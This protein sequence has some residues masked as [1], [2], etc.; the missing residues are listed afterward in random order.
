MKQNFLTRS[1]AVAIATMMT[2]TGCYDDSD[3][4][5]RMDQAEA[6]IAELQQ[7]VKDINTNISGLVTVVD[8]LKNSDQITSVTPLSDGSGYTITFSK[9]GTITIYNGKNGGDGTNGTN[10][11]TGA[12][13]HTP[14]I[15]VKLDQDGQYYWTVDGEYLTD[16]EGKK[17]PATAHIATPQ[18]RINEGNFEISYN[19]GLTWEV[20][21]NAGASDDVVFK[22]VID[23]PASV[24]FVL[25][26]GTQIEI[27]K[28]QQFEINVTSTDVVASAGQQ[29]FVDFTVSGA[30]ENTVVDA[31]GTKGYEASVMMMNASTGSLTI[32]VPDPMT[33]GKVYLMAVK[34]DGSTAARIFSCEEGVF[35]VDETAFAAKVPAA[36]GNVEVPVTTNISGWGVMVDP[37]NLWIKHVETKA[38]R[39]ETVVLSVEENTSTEERTG[40]V[41]IMPP[42]ETGG[43]MMTYTIVQAGASDTPPV[44][45]GGGSA[46][47]ETING[48]EIGTS[49]AETYT[50]TNGWYSSNAVVNKLSASKYPD[51][52]D[53]PCRPKLNIDGTLTSPE[54][55]GGCGTLTITWARA[56][57][58]VGSQYLVEIKNSEGT[59]LKS[60]THVEAE[61]AQNVVNVSTF[62][63]NVAGDFVVVITNQNY[64]AN[65]TQTSN[66]SDTM[67]VIDVDWTG[68][69]E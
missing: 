45:T 1:L 37:G 12:D 2:F 25:S 50:T 30:D 68:Y 31:F 69:S 13:G 24:L 52:Q 34:S 18:I 9:S 22:Q 44:V 5:T 39:I 27:P 23:G 58:K 28:T 16:A 55:S 38:V 59:V 57:T 42:M 33:D 61:A 15:S 7:L 43:M 53:A 6:D 8:A 65:D 11:E 48:G 64:E 17:I 41:I 19:E 4:Q 60:E 49:K 56:S 21:G 32:T 47:L 46:D 66:A 14:V 62:N 10:G 63:M 29:A 26:D 20:I 35:S 51:Y 36:G 40:K 54:L 67:F 3:L